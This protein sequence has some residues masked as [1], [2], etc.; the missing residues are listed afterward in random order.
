LK[1]FSEKVAGVKNVFTFALPT[2]TR[3]ST[4][5][6]ESQNGEYKLK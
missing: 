2:A 1:V 6:N 3:Y 4:S 5:E